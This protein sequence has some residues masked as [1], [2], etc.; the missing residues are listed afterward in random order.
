MARNLFILVIVFGS[1]LAGILVANKL[2][3]K[4]KKTESAPTGF[5]GSLVTP[6]RKIAVPA[7]SKDDGS[8][9]TNADLQDHWTLM[10]FGYTHCPDICPTTLNMLA[11][12]RKKSKEIF[13]EVVFVSVDPQRDSVEMLGEYVEYF[14]PSFTGVTGDEALIKALTLQMSVVYVQTPGSNSED[15]LVDHSS[16]ILLL[17]QE[18]R[19]KAFINPP[20]TP[21][22]IID[23]V[24]A[25]IKASGE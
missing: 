24:N 14:D 12:A 6:A 2:A 19:L 18:G 9:F 5:H 16:A 4:Q 3:D 8:V 25:I 20:H 15:Y 23:S 10:F 17:N 21:K 13:P 1:M 7:L 22:S 11:L